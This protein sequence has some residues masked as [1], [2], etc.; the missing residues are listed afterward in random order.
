MNRLCNNLENE[1]VG[2]HSNAAN[3]TEYIP[4]RNP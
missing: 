3:K 4:V 2:A 1:F